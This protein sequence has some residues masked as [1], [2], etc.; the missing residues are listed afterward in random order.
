MNRT[1]MTV[2]LVAVLAGVG[3]A[4]E[5][6]VRAE[7]QP[8]RE[9]KLVPELLEI[10]AGAGPEEELNVIV[11]TRVQ[12]D[13]AAL[14][15]STGY[16][17]K[18]SH[19]Q[20]TA[21]A[22]QRDILSWL[23]TTGARDVRSF[24]LVSG[25]ALTATPEVIRS[26][27][28]RD[29]VQ[30]VTDDFIITVGA[31]PV[32]PL[33]AAATAGTDL[34]EWNINKVRAPECWAAGF[35]GAG[36]VVG[37]ID[38]GVYTSHPAFGGRWRSSNGW[39]DG[40]SG[41][42]SPYDDNGHGTHCMGSAV[43]GSGIGVA[44]GATFIAAKALNAQGSGQGSWFDACLE[45]MAGTG[46]PDVLS[47]SWGT[48]E[49]T[50]TY[51]FNHFVNLRSLGVVVVG[52]VGN[53]GPGTETSLPPGS[54]PNVIGVGATNSGDG[55]AYFSSRGPAPN[56]YP[57]W[58]NGF[59]P[60]PD[61]NLVN[62]GIS[63]P[64]ENIRSAIPGGGYYSLDGTSMAAPHV[65]GAAALLLQKKSDLTHD[66]IFNLFANHAVRP[67]GG[68]PY[69]N[70]N[71]G[72]G[73]LDCKAALD[74]AGG[75]G[76]DEETL[77]V[78][79]VYNDNAVGLTNGG[80]FYTAARLTPTRGNCNV[81]A[82][83][84]LHHEASQ[85]Q[86]FFVWRGSTATNPGAVVES[87]P[88][89]GSGTGWK[90]VELTQPFRVNAGE[91]V[92][93]GPRY[94]HAAGQFPGGVDGGPPVSQR[95]GWLNYDGS[96]IELSSAG[97]DFNWMVAA[98]VRYDGAVEEDLLE[99]LPAGPAVSAPSF[100]V[101]PGRVEYSLPG[102]GRAELVVCDVSGKLVRML[103]SGV[104]PAGRHSAGWDLTDS[105]GRR[106]ASGTYLFRLTVGG[107]TQTSRSVVLD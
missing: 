103:A 54:Y 33:T 105:R 7:A 39:F 40:V 50:S 49:R 85:N 26:M 84:F 60:R 37:N 32:P 21:E 36:I 25:I 51:F 62:P 16:D 55:I 94:Q 18:I 29:D 63:A 30:F 8:G 102:A 19:L 1:V 45:W 71:Y 61:W 58:D 95:G 42:S 70:N 72:W 67:S 57:W 100:L 43:G 47:N 23:A 31:G 99:P 86:R 17:E 82:G 13:L 68:S 89:T 53:E 48:S 22:A 75:G 76:G 74:N 15:P 3:F 73:R 11:R 66:E 77:K 59:W 107:R 106:V 92:W 14:P 4:G 79:Y 24:W 28:A 12:A 27:A 5:G 96:W 87:I 10:L 90:R 88:Y 46:R 56:R 65:A 97:L 52:A 93:L 9:L 78:H 83:I 35:N 69:P 2:A 44:P 98:I 38:T 64:G 81:V 91:D 101:N 80:V 41:Q 6:S 104:F 34:Q 20:A